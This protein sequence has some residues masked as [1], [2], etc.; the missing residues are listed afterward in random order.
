MNSNE[1]DNTKMSI[2]SKKNVVVQPLCS[3]KG[4]KRKRDTA[5]AAVV[6][7][8]QDKRNHVAVGEV[9]YHEFTIEDRLQNS[10]VESE[11][12]GASNYEED[13]DEK[14]NELHPETDADFIQWQPS[15]SSCSRI[16]WKFRSKTQSGPWDC[17]PFHKITPT[18]K[19]KWWGG[20][21]WTCA[22]VVK[23][24]GAEVKAW[25]ASVIW[26]CLAKNQ[27]VGSS[28]KT[29]LIQTW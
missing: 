9:R 13:T 20:A 15:T 10:D 1:A 4:R 28:A 17:N 3:F 6:I 19:Q 11:Y 29:M 2:S 18:P 16:S 24:C 21:E 22:E 25:V 23:T 27:T 26:W 12:E 7:R 14:E 5:A 8:I